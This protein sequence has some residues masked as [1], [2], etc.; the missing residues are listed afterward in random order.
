MLRMR[1]EPL[2]SIIVPV[3]NT[4]M[5]IV[6]CIESILQQTYKNIEILLINDGSTDMSGIICEKYAFRDQRIKYFKQANQGLSAARNKGLDNVTGEYILFVDSDD[7][8]DENAVETFLNIAVSEN[9]DITILEV[10]T[11]TVQGL[12][13]SPKKELSVA[14]SEQLREKILKDK[15]GN[16]VITKCFK[17]DLW[18]SVRFPLGL[19][20][21]D[22]FIMPRL[23]SVANKIVYRC[24]A[25]Y[26]YNRCNENSLTYGKNDFNA[27]HRYSKFLAYCEHEKAG[28]EQ[29]SDDIINWSI[30]KALHES[31]K[32]FVIDAGRPVLRDAQRQLMKEYIIKNEKHIKKLNIKDRLLLDSI[33]KTGFLYKF[34]G[35]VKRVIKY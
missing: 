10:K 22:L 1:K 34:Y 11:E 26:F 6:R 5:F 3:Y 25:V 12:Q 4:E 27:F 8:L 21:E 35:I 9:A 24:E 16:H 7:Y 14:S 23:V 29:K 13:Y 31:V 18:N 33:I 2:V 15:I 20:Y 28:I 19:V 30:E 17:K 32:A